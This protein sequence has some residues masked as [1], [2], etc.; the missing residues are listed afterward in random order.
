[1]ICFTALLSFTSV[2]SASAD[3]ILYFPQFADGGGYST[4]WYFTGMSSGTS[5]VT[6]ELFDQ[7]GYPLT[8]ASNLGTSSIFRITL[9]GSS[10]ASLSTLGSA[11]SPKVGWTRVTATQT[12]GAT[13]TYQLVDT[14]GALISAAAVLPSTPTGAATLLVPDSRT[15]AI[16]VANTGSSSITLNFRL[17]DQSGVAVASGTQS[18]GASNQIASFVNQIPS[19]ASSSVFGGSLEITAPSPF[20]LATLVYQGKNFAGSPILPGRNQDRAGI[21][22]QLKSVVQQMLSL[23]DEFLSP[24]QTDITAYASFLA[25]PQT[26][27]TRLLPGW[28]YDD[29]FP[30]I[31]GGAFWGFTSLSHDYEAGADIGLDQGYLSVGFAGYDYGFIASLGDVPIDGVT[32][33]STG[34]PYLISYVPPTTDAAI[35]A[36]QQRAGTGFTVGTNSYCSRML[37]KQSTTYVLRSISYGRSD[38]LV[39]FRVLRFDTDGSVIF[40]W[41]VLTTFPVPRYQ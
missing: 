8:V 23:D 31:G 24:A 20:S 34:V 4:T 25:Q 27:I 21:L 17:L 19:L 28:T 12:I 3:Q 10:S 32:V 37:A 38:L 11:G 33:A 5:I 26:G 30:Y 40:V 41:K 18:L 35:R 39:A 1:V 16:A 7:T 9:A 36:E 13:E 2:S 22:D 15:T 29:V 6:I 14:G